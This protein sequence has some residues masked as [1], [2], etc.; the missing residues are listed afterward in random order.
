L[1]LSYFTHQEGLRTTISLRGDL[2]LSTNRELTGLLDTAIDDQGCTT[3]VVNLAQVTF[4][5]S[6]TIGVLVRKRRAAEQAGLTFSVAGLAD[7]VRTV[8]AT[9]GVLDYLTDQPR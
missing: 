2:D 9:A 5:D 7:Q 6:V 1:A 4:I 3:I 8:L